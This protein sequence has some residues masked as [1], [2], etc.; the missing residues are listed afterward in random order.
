M[1]LRL[2]IFPEFAFHFCSPGHENVPDITF[3][4]LILI[5]PYLRQRTS[6]SANSRK[7][8]CLKI[9]INWLMHSCQVIHV[10]TMWLH[11][12]LAHD[13]I[14]PRLQSKHLMW[15]RP[16][17]TLEHLHITVNRWL[18][19]VSPMLD[20]SINR[21]LLQRSNYCVFISKTFYWHAPRSN[22]NIKRD[23]KDNK[24]TETTTLQ[25]HGCSP[26]ATT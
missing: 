20:K 14:F 13:Q 7:Y 17:L 16:A 11:H 15:S 25:N 3:C 24:I 10:C 4:S 21:G 26:F 2:Y 19:L 9:P 1:F 8:F 22:G 23:C 12:G 18:Y 5:I 6:F